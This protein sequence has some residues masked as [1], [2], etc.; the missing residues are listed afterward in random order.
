[1][2]KI[3]LFRTIAIMIVL[4]NI[5]NY[6]L[7]AASYSG[8]FIR[9]SSTLFDYSFINFTN[10]DGRYVKVGIA[11]DN[12]FPFF[13]TILLVD[14]ILGY[15]LIFKSTKKGDYLDMP[16]KWIN[17]MCFLGI[18]VHLFLLIFIVASSTNDET[19]FLMIGK[20]MLINILWI[21]GYIV[22][23]ELFYTIGSKKIDYND[24]FETK[25]NVFDIVAISFLI[26]LVLAFFY[27]SL[28]N[29]IVDGK[30]FYGRVYLSQ[31]TML[32]KTTNPYGLEGKVEN[33]PYIITI[34]ILLFVQIAL[35][36]FK[37]KFKTV[38]ITVLS[39]IN[40]VILTIGLVD[41]CD[42]IYPNYIST[43]S[44]NF[45]ILVGVGYYF[46]IFLNIALLGVNLYNRMYAKAIE[47]EKKET[48]NEEN[49]DTLKKSDIE[50][51]IYVINEEIGRD[52]YI[53]KGV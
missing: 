50:D 27:V 36:I 53:E 37:T 1:M 44:R 48:K 2:K 15:L 12:R 30:I 19:Y 13:V 4:F 43:N 9:E 5:I 20:G 10:I 21:I 16:H 7:M 33:Y 34:L 51:N 14:L 32:F 18:L 22:I 28:V 45:F 11:S 29:R 8:L 40:I 24:V 6:F 49:N 39:I 31:Y 41:M 25:I 35:S 42:S 26:E 3:E 17:L 38:I 47:K 46:I 52:D 23:F